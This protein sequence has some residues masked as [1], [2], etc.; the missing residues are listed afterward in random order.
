[1]NIFSAGTFV[2]QP[3]RSS[4][5]SCDELEEVDENYQ[6]KLIRKLKHSAACQQDTLRLFSLRAVQRDRIKAKNRAVLED[7]YMTRK[8]HERERYKRWLSSTKRSPY[9]VDLVAEQQKTEEE[10]AVR[11]MVDARRAKLQASHIQQATSAIL[12]RAVA[13]D[14]ECENLRSEKRALVGQ[15]KQLRAMRDVEKTSHRSNLVTASRRKEELERYQRMMENA[16]QNS[17]YS[18]VCNH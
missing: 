5:E 14:T 12:N 3:H 8:Q 2:E 9:S 6:A 1:M 7:D 10:L 4:G 18:R 15:E 11:K 17:N 13:R 16:L